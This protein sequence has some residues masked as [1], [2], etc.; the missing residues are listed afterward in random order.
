MNDPAATEQNDQ[1]R[2]ALALEKLETWLDEQE[3]GPNDYELSVRD[4]RAAIRRAMSE[5]SL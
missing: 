3:Q 1:K 4:V 2:K 5:V